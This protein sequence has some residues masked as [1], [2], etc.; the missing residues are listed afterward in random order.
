MLARKTRI[1]KIR[2]GVRPGRLKGKDLA[3]LRMRCYVR[4]RACCRECGRMTIFD[5]PHTWGDSYHMHH[6]RGKRM[7]GDSL[8][9]VVTLCGAC[10]R[11]THC[12][13]VVPP[14]HG[15]LPN[16]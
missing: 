7:W 1:R 10:H 6:V 2:K 11:N 3:E 8:E 12:P 5:A 9:N 13:K 15:A 4:D 14:K 16:G